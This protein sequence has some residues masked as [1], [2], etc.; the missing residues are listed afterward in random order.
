[1]PLKAK[2]RFRDFSKTVLHM[3]AASPICIFDTYQNPLNWRMHV[4]DFFICHLS[5]VISIHLK[6]I[7][8]IEGNKLKRGAGAPLI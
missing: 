7:L 8:T 3:R 4:A 2:I 6:T 1:M 5:R